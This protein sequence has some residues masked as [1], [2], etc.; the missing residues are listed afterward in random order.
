MKNYHST[1]RD[2]YGHSFEVKLVIFMVKK[3]FFIKKKVIKL[4]NSVSINT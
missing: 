2:T 1:E 3:L 4:L